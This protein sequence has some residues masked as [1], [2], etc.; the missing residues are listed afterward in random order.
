M[1]L[2]RIHIKPSGG[3]DDMNATFKHCLD[4]KLLGIGWG[5][6]G[7]IEKTCDWEEYENLAKDLHDSIQQP[8]YI[9]NKVS[10]GDLVWTRDPDSNYYLAHVTSGW[11]YWTNQ[12]GRIKSIDI[13]NIFRCEFYPI[14]EL[15]DKVPGVI[16]S[17]FSRGRAIQRIHDSS[18]RAYSQHIWNE[19]VKQEI[20]DVDLNELPDIFSMLNAEET[21]DLVFLYL[22][23][24]GWYVVPN[25]RKGNTLR[26]E[27]RLSDRKTGEKA[28]TQVKT[29]SERLNI[30][31]YAGD[32]KRIFLFQ[33]NENYDGEENST[34]NVTLI[35]RHELENFLAKNTKILPQSIQTRLNMISDR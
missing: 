24:L 32:K 8:R 11:E 30:N 13:A 6:Y 16:V 14:E 31:D 27:F 12:N 20:Y 29:G 7:I 3:T 15:D 28:W 5:V 35:Y 34:E 18:A 17:S 2:H 33:S 21:E 25:S 4:N 1:N 23:S 10:K 19:H 9:L 26:F 22:Q